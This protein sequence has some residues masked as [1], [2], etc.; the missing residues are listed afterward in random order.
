MSDSNNRHKQRRIAP[1]CSTAHSSVAFGETARRRW[2]GRV[3]A[4]YGNNSDRSQLRLYV[5]WIAL[6]CLEN[7]HSLLR[8]WQ[9]RM[10]PP[11]NRCW[12][13]DACRCGHR[14]QTRWRHPGSVPHLGL[15][16][17][18]M[19]SRMNPQLLENT[20]DV[21]D[22][23]WAADDILIIQES[24]QSFSWEKS[25]ADRAQSSVQPNWRNW[26]SGRGF[27][28]QP[29]KI[30]QPLGQLGLSRSSD[31]LRLHH[32]LICTLETLLRTLDELQAR[33]QS[34]SGLSSP[35]KSTA[36]CSASATRSS[37]LDV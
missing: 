37:G 35:N 24:E 36:A 33:I 16:M 15:P 3:P 10:T 8:T 25:I 22:P 32:M 4:Q 1:S 17:L 13:S 26:R 5:V 18:H 29:L 34:F 19:N 23:L 9:G 28:T 7:F 2:V 30:C 6:R 21:G 14:V 11:H 31:F 12:I 20:M 27:R